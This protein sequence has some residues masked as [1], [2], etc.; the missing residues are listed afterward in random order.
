MS[1]QSG[2]GNISVLNGIRGLAVLIVFA[3]H[4]SNIFFHGEVSGFGAGQLGV[5]LFFVLSGF[6]MAHL[7]MDEPADA[8]SQW[9]FA[10]NRIARI[11]P[12]FAVV[13]LACLV[14]HKLGLP[15]WAYPITSFRDALINLSFV[16]GYDI[17][18]TIGPEVIF[19]GLFL[20][21]WRAWRSSKVG[22]VA[23]VLI[24]TAVAWLPINISSLNSLTRLHEKLPY[25][26]L[27][28]LIGLRPDLFVL[29]GRVNKNVAQLAFWLFMA[30][31]IAS[32]PQ[33]IS[34]FVDTPARLTGN[35][36]PDPWSFPFYLLVIGGLFVTA[37]MAR[38]W[39][40]E[41]SAAAFLGRISFSFYLF[42]FAVLVNVHQWL[43]QHPLR[44]IALA[45]VVTA[46][47]ASVSFVAVETPL[48]RV[49]RRLGKRRVTDQSN[50]SA[51]AH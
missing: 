18:W 9:R 4:S 24:M 10:V 34:L 31:T 36:W 32:F 14:I 33:I 17:L 49:I 12:A 29:G 16:R 43:P 26:L 27:G 45:F 35:P 28:C 13:V 41:T 7:Y 48:R 42:H 39:I 40:L 2:H 47:L 6:L 1:L 25:F 5:M 50:D 38:P 37:L 44:A 23:L 30:I 11:Y 8:A 51:G 22:F 15:I 19:Y 20:L 21:L 46:T 3:S